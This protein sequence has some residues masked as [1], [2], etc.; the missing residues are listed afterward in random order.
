MR[1]RI[2]LM[3]VSPDD[4]QLLREAVVTYLRLYAMADAAT[5]AVCEQFVAR[6][7]EQMRVSDSSAM[8]ALSP[9]IATVPA[10]AGTGSFAVSVMGEGSWMVT[11]VEPWLRHRFADGAAD[12]IWAGGL[13]YRG[14]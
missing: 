13:Q 7:D 11:A 4:A 12:G 14:A 3:S 10:E 9:N 5:Q 2:R 8:V 1:K 6:V